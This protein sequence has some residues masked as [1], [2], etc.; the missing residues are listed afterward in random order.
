MNNKN[1]YYIETFKEFYNRINETA[2]HLKDEQRK[3]LNIKRNSDTLNRL[4]TGKTITKDIP[5]IN[6]TF[7][8]L[9][10]KVDNDKGKGLYHKVNVNDKD[11][12]GNDHSFH[13]FSQN[14][15]KSIRNLYK[16]PK[17]FN[18][19]ESYYF[20]DAD[21][22][23]YQELLESLHTIDNLRILAF[24]GKTLDGL[25]T[26]GIA[27]YHIVDNII[28]LQKSLM[29]NYG[30][31]DELEAFFIHELI[32][33]LDNN[34]IRTVYPSNLYNVNRKIREAGFKFQ[35]DTNLFSNVFRQIASVNRN[36]YNNFF[37]PYTIDLLKFLRDEDYSNHSTQIEIR[38]YVGQ[39]LY[40]SKIDGDEQAVKDQMFGWQYDTYEID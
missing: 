24:N 38:A 25:Y 29:N 4:R 36:N 34:N 3:Q 27:T 16:K 13:S 37:E 2:P 30:K 33:F 22:I 20:T 21:I 11:E 26:D 15:Q 35:I 14:K 7:K 6:H 19:N 40:W 10:A 23:K 5:Y 12:Y 17:T 1:N 8:N 39:F 31:Q 32:H 18:K 9:S 28:Y